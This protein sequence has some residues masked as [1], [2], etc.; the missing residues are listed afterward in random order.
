MHP[1]N[2][3]RKGK[4]PDAIEAI[5]TAMHNGPPPVSARSATSQKAFQEMVDERLL[6]TR[7]LQAYTVLYLHGPLTRNQMNYHGEKMFSTWSQLDKRLAQLIANGVA[8]DTGVEVKCPITGF[9]CNLYDT[10]GTVPV[11]PRAADAAPAD[12]A[13]PRPT[14]AERAAAS[15]A[16]TRAVEAFDLELGDADEAVRKTLAWLREGAVCPLPHR[17]ARAKRETR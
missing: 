3:A 13:A 9:S 10:A 7:A 17:V 5:L 11:T 12:V 1:R 2:R 4:T 16:L 6:P 14:D 15:A 8:Q